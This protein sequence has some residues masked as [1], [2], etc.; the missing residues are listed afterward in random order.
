MG[1][2]KLEATTISSGRICWLDVSLWDAA[3]MS[4]KRLFAAAL[5][6]LISLLTIPMSQV[7]V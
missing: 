7:I 5:R 3:N 4:A 2:L 6:F 1:A